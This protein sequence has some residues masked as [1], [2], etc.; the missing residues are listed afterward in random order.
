VEG[1]RTGVEVR[2]MNSFEKYENSYA[3]LDQS[4]W[5]QVE[6]WR[7]SCDLNIYPFLKN[8]GIK[9]IATTESAQELSYQSYQPDLLSGHFSG[10]STNSGDKDNYILSSTNGSLTTDNLDFGG[11]RIEISNSIQE[12]NNKDLF[13]PSLWDS[14]SAFQRMKRNKRSKADISN[15]YLARILSNQ[16]KNFFVFTNDGDQV[17]QSEIEGFK[18]MRPIEF[19]V[20]LVKDEYITRQKGV[21]IFE[22]MK[23]HDPRWFDKKA[24]RF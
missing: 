8:K 23:K 5:Q 24:A 2:S 9:V 7:V 1:N 15:I 16:G 19:L 13:Q 3:I 10:T 17:K 21:W 14:T 12:I 6:F 11:Y 20:W 4:A 22:K 18:Y